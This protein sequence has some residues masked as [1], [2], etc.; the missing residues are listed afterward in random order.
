MPTPHHAFTNVSAGRA[1]RRS[2]SRSRRRNVLVA[3]AIA[4]PLLVGIPLTV[5]ADEETAR[6][7]EAIVVLQEIMNAPDAAIPESQI[8]RAS[9]RERV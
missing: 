6:I 7:D 5:H 1:G 8:G 9:W 2:T 3:A 4:G